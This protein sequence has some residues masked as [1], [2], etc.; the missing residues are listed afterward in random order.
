MLVANWIGVKQHLD[1]FEALTTYPS[2]DMTAPTNGSLHLVR[3]MRINAKAIPVVE[4]PISDWATL[5]PFPDQSVGADGRC[6]VIEM[7]LRDGTT[8]HVR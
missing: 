3:I 4:A 6:I 7:I 1:S 8:S 5:L 2:G